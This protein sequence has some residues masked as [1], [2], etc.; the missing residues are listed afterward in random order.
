MKKKLYLAPMEGITGYVYRNALNKYFG[1]IDGY[2]TPFISP[3]HNKILNHKELH[4]ILPENNKGISVIPQILANDSGLFIETARQLKEY[5]YNEVNLNLG[6]PS[7]TVVSKKKGSGLLADLDMLDDFLFKIYNE[8]NGK[9]KMDISIKTRIGKDDVDEFKSLLIIY[10][11]YPVKLLTI[12][13]RI[14]RELYKGKCHLEIFE[15]AVNESKNPLCYNGDINSIDDFEVISKKFPDVDNYMIGR[16]ILRNPFLIEGIKKLEIQPKEQIENKMK[17]MDKG[18]KKEQ[19]ENKMKIMDKGDKTADKKKLRQFHDEIYAGYE[20]I[21]SG[22]R[23]VLFKMKE[24][25][26]YMGDNF[27][28]DAKALKQIRKATKKETYYSAINF[29][30]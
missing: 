15:M 2:V 10:N 27:P 22:D 8:V 29:I 24:L 7:G 16:G 17:I 5:G 3:T 4:D 18:D 23:N 12:H 14:Q 6:C 20:E 9:M 30:L 19:I 1:G 11:Q 26:S 21:F 28:D 13:P 25:W